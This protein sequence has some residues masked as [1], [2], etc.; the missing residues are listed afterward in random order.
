VVSSVT[1]T[2]IAP[3]TLR[4]PSRRRPAARRPAPGVSD[5]S[6]PERRQRTGELLAEAAT[7]ADE[8]RR[9]RLHDEVVR[10]NMDVAESIASRFRNRGIAEDD[11]TQVAYLGL[12]KAVRRYDPQAPHDF[13][14]FAVPTIRGE[15]KRFFR[16]HG[17]TVR[18]P[19]RIQELQARIVSVDAA[20]SQELGRKPRPREIAEALGEETEHVAAAMA[21]NGC[22]TPVSLDAPVGDEQAA[23]VGDLLQCEDE[24]PR[25]VDARVILAP[26]VRDLPERDRRILYLRFFEGRTQ[27]EI[28]D[29][30]G[31]TQMQVSRLLTRILGDLRTS[32]AAPTPA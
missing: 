26:A 32:L 14:S 10:L 3:P 9:R 11:L 13:L 8:L 23:S 21:A 1:T 7:T 22:F 2:T 5:V 24:G 28:G 18:P 31:V 19:R 4:T 29:E 25:A 27:R 12:G 30:L 20:L 15:V 17:W 16:D 6:R